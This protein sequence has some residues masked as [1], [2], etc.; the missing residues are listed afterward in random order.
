M[1]QTWFNI[2]SVLLVFGLAIISPGPNLI[3]VINRSLSVSRRSGLY[4]SLGIATGSGLFALAGLIGLLLLIYAIPYFATLIRF[5][6][7]GYLLYLGFGM[8]F[9]GNR[10]LPDLR[11]SEPAEE[12]QMSRF[13]TWRSG[14]LSNLTNPKAWAFYLSLFSLFINISFPLWAKL[15]LTGSIFLISWGWYS[16]MAVLISDQR[17]Q[18]KFSKVQPVVTAGLGGLLVLFGSKWLLGL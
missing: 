12:M 15:F 4:T 11:Q 18:E 7:G 3:L 17:L 10:M 9:S 6:G 1:E 8:L 13:S 5:A 14:L 16:S 2:F